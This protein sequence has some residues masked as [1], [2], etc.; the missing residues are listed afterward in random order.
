MFTPTANRRRRP[1][2]SSERG[3]EVS[4]LE[5]GERLPRVDTAL[6]TAGGLGVPLR[7]LAMTAGS[8]VTWR[9]GWVEDSGPAEY[10]ISED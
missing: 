4:L 9:P 5:R 2:G 3:P 6:R 10:L 1:S 8:R 7:R